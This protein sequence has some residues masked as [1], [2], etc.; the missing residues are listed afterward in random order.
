MQ[1]TQRKFGPTPMTYDL[2]N[3]KKRKFYIGQRCK[4]Q[5]DNGVPGPTK[6]KITEDLI[7]KLSLSRFSASL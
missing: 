1:E 3:H 5:L 2:T 6:Y 7:S 4:T